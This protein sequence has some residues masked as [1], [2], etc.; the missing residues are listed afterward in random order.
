MLGDGR[1]QS[2][3]FRSCANIRPGGVAHI[4]AKWLITVSLIVTLGFCAICSSILWEMRRAD[5]EKASQASINVVATIGAD[6]A[7]NIE[8][9]DLSLQAV[10]DGLKL[11]QINQVNKDVRQLI[12]F[13]R[14][15]AAKHQGA[16]RVLDAVGTVIDD[17]RSG[18]TETD[19]FFDRDYFQIHKQNA[20]AGL[21]ISSPLIRIDGQYVIGISRRVSNPD[22]S[23]AGVVVGELELSYFHNLFQKVSLGP[24]SSMGLVRTDGTMLM[25]SPFN[26]D[27]IGRDLSL[28][29]IFKNIAAARFGQFEAAAA[30]D[31][32]QRLHT[33]KRA[34]DYPVII[35]IGVSIDEIYAGWRQEAW[36]IGLLILALCA[37]TVALAIFLARELRRRSAAEQE[38]ALLASID[39]LTGLSNRRSF[40]EVFEREWRRSMRQG[41]AIAL[42]MID[43]DCFKEY[44]DSYG[45]QAGDKALEAI[46]GCISRGA[47]RPADFAARYGGEEFVVL[48]SDTSLAGA[49]QV[50]ERIRKNVIGL[51]SMQAAS[52]QILTVSIGIASI[53]PQTGMQPCDLIN[54]A[55]L[56]L[57]EAKRTGRNRTESAQ[58]IPLT[59]AKLKLVA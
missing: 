38:L 56:A 35:M 3:N 28:S 47:R 31:G 50:A 34:G 8:L 55:D 44:N 19:N 29:E 54:A 23:F 17:S 6:I 4:S 32:V 25:R 22:G 41:T 59:G 46:A 36:R 40:D 15:T 49:F 11:P 43:A 18:L 27:D 5:W 10:V 20:N 26:F 42:L 24:E 51:G 13:N 9:Y 21:Y 30:V 37:V 1:V 2:I 53:V 14:A 48:L 52:T 7:R 58:T 45:H 33:F 39:G 12:L 16:I 57:Y